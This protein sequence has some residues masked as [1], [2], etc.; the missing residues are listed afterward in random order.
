MWD[1]A[2]ETSRDVLSHDPLCVECGHA[3]HTFLPCSDR[4]QCQPQDAPGGIR[5]AG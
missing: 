3:L 4:C 1:L 5:L 2:E